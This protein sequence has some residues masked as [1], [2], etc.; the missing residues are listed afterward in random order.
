MIAQVRENDIDMVE[1][2]FQTL[3]EKLHTQNET[4]VVRQMKRMVPEFISQNSVY[5]Q[6][7]KE[8]QDNVLG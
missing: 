7:D 5:E 1:K 3:F 6:L 8:Q 4:E 2:S